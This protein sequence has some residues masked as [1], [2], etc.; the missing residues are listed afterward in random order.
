MNHP[1]PSS[2]TGTAPITIITG[3]SRGLGLALAEQ[4][5]AQGHHVLA[6]ARQRPAL[7][8]PALTTWQADL[9]EASVV[10]AQL[11]RWLAAPEQVS[12]SAVSL[13]NNAGVVSQLAPLSAITSA[14]LVNALRVGLEAPTLL[15]AAF[16]R[17]TAGWT[18]PRKLL[19]ISSGLGRRAMAGSASYCAAKA[20]LDHLA[21]ATA[22]EEAALPNGA[23]VVSLAPGVIDTDMQVQLR[24][25][26]PTA[27]PERERFVGL[28]TGGQ[29]DSPATAA[30]KVLA[31]LARPDFGSQPVGDVRDA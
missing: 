9:A 24:S 1:T 5:L 26:D 20:G 17:A 19:H 30:A 22:L 29:L 16:L 2:T 31:Y 12:C 13:I 25:A 10:A 18:V 23:R 4:C 14:D 3:A 28:K 21:R 27:F 11:E 15:G 6:I 7:Q 8:H